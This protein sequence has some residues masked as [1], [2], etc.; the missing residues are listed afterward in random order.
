EVIVTGLP[1]GLGSCMNYDKKIDARLT[2]ELMSIQAIKGVY[3]GIGFEGASLK[4]SQF[5]DAIYYK[6]NKISRNTN[7]AGGVEGGMT[8]GEPLCVSCFMKPISTLMKP[9][10]SINIKTK[11]PA[12]AV[13]ERADVCALPAASV[14]A[15][16]VAA[17]TLLD[18]FMEKFGSDS[19]NELK[20]NY[21]G[22]VKQAYNI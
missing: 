21:K 5:H 11:K 18:A 20:R 19:M 13:V 16:N 22:Y 8:N 15:E 1:I 17:I 9:L 4:G 14:V 7:N 6:N 10:D 3:F 2:L 12:K